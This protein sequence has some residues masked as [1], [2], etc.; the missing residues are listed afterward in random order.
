MWGLREENETLR[1]IVAQQDEVLEEMAKRTVEIKLATEE[2]KELMELRRKREAREHEEVTQNAEEDA[3]GSGKG[4]E[5][6]RP[7]GKQKPT[8]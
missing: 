4:K 3:G 1:D 6:E 2:R 7:R 5:A 8:V